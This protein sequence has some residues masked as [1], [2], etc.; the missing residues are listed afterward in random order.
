[1]E[2]AHDRWPNSEVKDIVNQ[3]GNG[4]GMEDIVRNGMGFPV[5]L[6]HGNSAGHLP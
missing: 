3:F 1:V 2:L 5:L 6:E 4:P